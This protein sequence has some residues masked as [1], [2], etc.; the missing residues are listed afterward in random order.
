[1][2]NKTL[3]PLVEIDLDVL[4]EVSI[5]PIT[6]YMSIKRGVKNSIPPW[7]YAQDHP[8]LRE[9]ALQIAYDAMINDK[10]VSI[11]TVVINEIY[12]KP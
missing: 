3:T 6:L 7:K 9:G 2:C 10:T 11:M 4:P 8:E 12:I 5:S 1:M